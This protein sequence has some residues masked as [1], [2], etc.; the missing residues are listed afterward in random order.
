MTNLD[1]NY[2]ENRYQNQEIG[3]DVG[4]PTTPIKAFVDTLT[5]K[6]KRVLIPGA[7]SGYEAAYLWSLGFRNLYV[8][9]WANAAKDRF[10]AQ[11]PDFPTNQFIVGD[12]FDLTEG[13]YDLIVEQTFFCAIDPEL[14]PDYAQKCAELL[15]AKGI[16]AGVLFDKNF[17]I[18]P[19]FGGNREEYETYFLPY[20][21]IKKMESCYNSIPPRA[22]T[23]LWIYL[24]KK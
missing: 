11:I 18:N 6:N 12:F 5:D 14:R 23:E 15:N 2:W 21:D 8:C 22:N 4:K 24:E 1:Q 17:D 13:G 7:G 20:F 16:L 3:W 10:L 9:D 19:P